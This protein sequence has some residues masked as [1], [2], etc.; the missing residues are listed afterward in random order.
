MR[1]TISIQDSLLLQAKEAS[2]A[3]NCSLG[4]VVEDAL[5][6]SLATRSKSAKGGQ[7]RPLKT[8]RGSGLQPGVDLSSS[9]GLLEIMEGQ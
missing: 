7:A 1:T 6:L 5:R 4:E 8:F 2:L 3:R 9:S